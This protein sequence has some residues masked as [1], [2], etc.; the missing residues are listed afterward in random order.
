MIYSL[1]LSIYFAV[2]TTELKVHDQLAA[3]ELIF[4]AHAV[5]FRISNS[6]SAGSVCT[7]VSLILLR[8]SPVAVH[9]SFPLKCS[10][11]EKRNP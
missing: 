10:L 3:L 4:L 6:P 7:R 9:P 8:L 5:W 11:K 1:V 2:Q